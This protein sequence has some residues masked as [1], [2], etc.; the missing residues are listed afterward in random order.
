MGDLSVAQINAGTGDY[1][2]AQC[3]SGSQFAADRYVL[4]MYMRLHGNNIAVD[5]ESM[6]LQC[7]KTGGT[8][9]VCVHDNCA[10]IRDIYIYI[11]M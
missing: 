5:T 10:D 2:C 9:P 6:L 1:V 3:V 8:T 11:Y 7:Q 4:F